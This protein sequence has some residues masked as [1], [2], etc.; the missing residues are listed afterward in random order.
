[1]AQ[2]APD[3]PRARAA[4]T[5]GFLGVLVG[6][7]PDRLSVVLLLL[8]LLYR[9][10]LLPV[11][12]PFSVGITCGGFTTGFVSAAFVVVVVLVVVMVLGDLADTGSAGVSSWACS[13]K[14]VTVEIYDGI[15]VR[16]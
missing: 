2:G 6:C 9:G 12:A 3:N 11:P 7:K 14:S 4:R 13:L 5:S 15:S 1:M 8:L 16:I 10:V